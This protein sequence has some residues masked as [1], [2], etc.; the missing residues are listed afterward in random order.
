VV[1][2]GLAG[3]ILGSAGG[4]HATEAQCRKMVAGKGA[5]FYLAVA[6]GFASCS[7]KLAA[8]LACDTAARDAKIQT[9]VAS[10]RASL[11]AACDAS[12]ATALGFAAPGDLA[13]R[14]AGVGAGEGRQVTDSVFGRI[15][16]ERSTSA[17]KCGFDVTTQVGKAGK[18]LIK[19]LAPCGSTCSASALAA[20][21][22]AYALAAT[23]ITAQCAPG[24]LASLV[25]SDPTGYLVTMR[26]GAQR[27]V[28]ALHP[29]A[30]PVV[31]VVTPLPGTVVVPPGLPVSVNVV[32]QVVNVPHAGYLNSLRVAG[33]D[34]TLDVSSGRFSQTVTVHNPRVPTVPL[35][36]EA[37]TTLGTVATTTNVRFDLSS[38]TPD[39]VIAAPLSGSIT[40]G[41]SIAV[42]GQVIGNR[43]AASVL[44][45]AGTPTSFDPAT[46]NFSTV[47]PLGSSGV[48]IVE[49][50]VRSLE[51]GTSGT[52]S[53]V[54]LTGAALPLTSRVPGANTN[55]LNNSGF[56]QVRGVIQADL[57]PAFAPVNFLGQKAGPGTI[58]E[59]STGT[60]TVDVFGGGANT[61]TAVVSIDAFHIRV[62]GV[63]PFNSCDGV[64]DA[65]NVTITTQANLVGQLQASVT[66]SDVIYTGAVATLH[67]NIL[68]GVANLFE[69]EGDFE[70]PLTAA[71]ESRIPAAFN[72]ALAGINISGPI[73]AALDVQ[74]DAS[75]ADIPE[76]ASGVSFLVD[77]NMIALDPV[78]DAPAITQTLVPAA[79]GPPVL[80]P[81]VPGTSTPYDLGFCLSDG[82]VNRAMAAFMLQGRFNQSLTAVPVGGT[83]IPLTTTVVSTLL[84]DPSYAAA[85][86][87]CN[88]TLVLRPTAGAVAHAPRPGE[89]ASVGLVIPN[90]RIDVVADDAGTPELLVSGVVTFDLPLTLNVS[91][92]TIAPA[93]GTIVVSNVKLT[94]NP[95]GASETAFANGIARLFPL[96]AQALG[97]LFGEIPLPSFQGL[98]VVGV[99]SGYNVSC[100]AI[101]LDLQP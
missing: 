12:V 73:G 90:Y 18:K 36:I 11:L 4:A 19:T 75:Y 48:N 61:V 99:A 67:G 88:V 59:F 26:S 21:D 14:V 8:G 97:A 84:G 44:L 78:P 87:G 9:R 39:V 50:E 60:K 70:A 37:R 65:T 74:I 93:V 62:S 68:C 7:R 34:A 25:G 53:V 38:L 49:A 69:L 85:C 6:K 3:S 54:V 29:G 31:S 92:S 95:I 72:D 24:D 30:T 46:G 100:T 47:V 41:S 94:S 77:A 33:E 89:S 55:R 98:Q 20:V 66:N 23:K 32:A 42:S 43:A 16:S 45:V 13:V 27:L 17:I 35:F 5:T 56:Q 15:P 81:L 64:F 71:F 22:S 52:D 79:V 2:A 57:V 91:G 28:D 80:G 1:L 96:A 86:P 82:F 58:T 76:D 101:Y 10:T 51:L 83:T 63:G 40:S